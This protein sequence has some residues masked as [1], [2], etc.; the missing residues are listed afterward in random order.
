M[1]WVAG[2]WPSQEQALSSLQV[3][4]NGSRGQ[5]Y[6][7]QQVG[8]LGSAISPD[9][10]VDG[11]GSHLYVLTAQRVRLVPGQGGHTHPE[12]PH[13]PPLALAA[14]AGGP[15]ARGSVPPVP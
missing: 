7:S 8:L 12:S 14:P 3:F 11:R 10:L 9:L 5:V 1:P 6:H 13:P 15:G 2:P 4:V